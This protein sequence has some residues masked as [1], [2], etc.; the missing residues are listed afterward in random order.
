MTEPRKF[1]NPFPGLRPFET[2]EYRLFFGREGQSDALLE[3]LARSRFLAVVGTSGSGKSSLIRAGLLPGLRGG[4]MAGAGSGWR[5]AVMRPGG[6]PA[7]NLARAL[8]A[9]DVLPQAG[10]GLPALEAEAVIEAT[11]RRGSLGLVDA[12]RQ[13]RLAENEKLLVVVDQF[14]ELFRFRAARAATSVDDD[15][16]AFVKLLLE[17]A[18][19]RDVAI[20]VVLTMRSDFLGDCAQF[21]NLPEAINDGQ[22]L[23]PRMTRD[24]R[25]VAITGPVGVTR[26]KIT[27]PLVNRLLNEVGDNPDQLPILQHALMRTW[28]YWSAHRL[29][30]SEPIGVEHYEAIG[31]MLDALSRHADEAWNEL[32]D[33]RSRHV[34][35]SLFKTLTERGSD[36]REIRRPTCLSDICKIAGATQDEVA[37]VVEIFR[38]EGRSFLMPPAG[39]E[40][41]GETVIDI[42][43]ESLIRNWERLREWVRDE[44]ESARIYR[45]LADAAV[46]YRNGEGG[47]LDEVT[48][49]WVNRWR[50]RYSPTRAWGLRYHP[51]YDEAMEYREASRMAVGA[52]AIE[53]TRQRE[54]ALERERREREQAE[55]FAGEQQ[56][57]AQRQRRLTRIL[58]VLST[59][60]IAALLIAVASLAHSW[61]SAKES[62]ES[63]ARAHESE[64]RALMSQREAQ[65]L[66]GDLRDSLGEVTAAKEEANRQ[67]DAALAAQKSAEDEK[68]RAVAAEQKEEDARLDAQAKAKVAEAEKVKA[69]S[70]E[71]RA[72]VETR[73]NIKA[74]EANDKFRDAIA[75]AQT[76][77]L[78]NA[79]SLLEQAVKG[80]QDRDVANEEAVADAKVQLGNLGYT[81]AYAGFIEAKGD[82]GNYGTV[83]NVNE[84]IA[85][86]DQAAKIYAGPKVHSPQKAASALYTLGNILMRFTKDAPHSPDAIADEPACLPGI[87]SLDIDVPNLSIAQKVNVGTSWRSLDYNPVQK[88]NDAALERYRQSFEYFRQASE[89]FQRA[90]IQSSS[91]DATDGMRKVAY[92]LGSFY[93]DGAQ[94]GGANPLVIDDNRRQ[95]VKHFE[96]L[97][98][99]YPPD[100]TGVARLLVL[101]AALRYSINNGDASAANYFERAHAAYKEQG[102]TDGEAFDGIGKISLD[103]GQRKA[104]ASYYRKAS[105]AY[106]AA[107]DQPSL[108]DVHFKLGELLLDQ[109]FE[110]SNVED[111]I[112]SAQN[113]YRQA[114]DAYKL[115]LAKDAKAEGVKNVFNIGFEAKNVGEQKLALDAFNLAFAFGEAENNLLL[116]ARAQDNLGEVLAQLNELPQSLAA[117]KES[118]AMYSRVLA[119]ARHRHNR[120]EIEEAEGASNRIM[121]IIKTRK[122]E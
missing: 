107:G 26:G 19:G 11:L 46:A 122:F 36:N 67:R 30:K 94:D 63:E 88:F 23:I 9:P 80:Y 35:E 37:S 4:L 113:H 109:G 41:S 90:G 105:E 6:D 102:R 28:D 82:F 91:A 95:A 73:K 43:H 87:S 34:A 62:Q 5:I 66:A 40:L 21:Q 20:Y 89:G 45:R 93:L 32:P 110:S 10:A 81:T 101:I 116:E 7:G 39:V 51:A 14:E 112:A 33:E 47:L 65:K 44:A 68:T 25:R 52:A 79:S 64:A 61:Q 120:S 99:L 24:E 77:D 83:E 13:G 76:G 104:A 59:L 69:Q 56:S 2:D 103:A 22:Y 57:A 48:L 1:T 8:A 75:R 17:A 108:A 60:A 97:L 115:A 3:R 106:R 15:A 31:T 54:E 50:D 16:A 12:A 49:G 86:Y 111:S 74:R 121:L 117:Y 53:R 92:Q 118:L 18:H 72:Q 55:R 96:T 58:F 119:S 29:D 85:N 98:S 38:R 84:A 71:A 42:S 100:D 114:L 70:E 27:E 78:E